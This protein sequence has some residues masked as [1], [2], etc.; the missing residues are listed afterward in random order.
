GIEPELLP[1]IFERFF[2]VEK[3]RSTKHGGAG[4]GLS[5]CKELVETLGGR[6]RV[7]SQT[8]EGTTFTVTLPQ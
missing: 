1:R 4:L 8:G 6:I 5:I 3:S 7:E 2:R